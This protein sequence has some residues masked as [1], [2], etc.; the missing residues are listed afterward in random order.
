MPMPS[1]SG[2]TCQVRWIAHPKHAAWPERS[3]YRKSKIRA[4]FCNCYTLDCCLVCVQ[5]TMY[6]ICLCTISV[7]DTQLQLGSK[8]SSAQQ[9]VGRAPAALLIARPACNKKTSPFAH[10]HIYLAYIGSGKKIILILSALFYLLHW[11]WVLTIASYMKETNLLLYIWVLNSRKDIIIIKCRHTE[12]W[13]HLNLIWQNFSHPF[14]FIIFRCSA[15]SS[16]YI[17][18]LFEAYGL[19]ESSG[20][21]P[22]LSIC[23]QILM[24]VH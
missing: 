4:L 23:L 11:I 24:L 14:R 13:L 20:N 15:K 5:L 7:I 12:T 10:C 16:P 2:T 3:R 8:W 17:T 6:R 18:V 1:Q 21:A 22:C 9:M 19:N